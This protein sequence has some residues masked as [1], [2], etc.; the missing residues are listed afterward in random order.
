VSDALTESTEH[1]VPRRYL[2]ILHGHPA[3]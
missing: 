3:A 2:E 1:Y